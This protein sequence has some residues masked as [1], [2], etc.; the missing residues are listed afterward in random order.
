MIKSSKSKLIKLT[1][2]PLYCTDSRAA[3][4]VQLLGLAYH[5]QEV[6]GT[7]RHS[8]TAS[9]AVVAAE[10]A[11]AAVMSDT[12]K[13]ARGGGDHHGAGVISEVGSHSPNSFGQA[14]FGPNRLWAEQA[15]GRKQ[16]DEDAV[17]A[18]GI[19]CGGVWAE[20]LSEWSSMARFTHAAC[21]GAL[22]LGGSAD[23]KHTHPHTHTHAHTHTHT[24]DMN[25]SAH[26]PPVCTWWL[27]G[28]IYL[29]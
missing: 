6:A 28:V 1:Q 8:P 26:L 15:L 18:H 25:M 4:A 21:V 13:G 23:E 22:L 9:Q 12:V 24:H 7:G 2:K 27:D 14:G 20:E 29:R 11:I 19:G 16:E 5:S 10:A 17:G 3:A